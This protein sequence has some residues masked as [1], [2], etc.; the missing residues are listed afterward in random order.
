MNFNALYKEKIK[1]IDAYISDYLSNY[2]KASPNLID[3]MKYSVLNGGKRLRSVLCTEICAMLGGDVQKAM[4]FAC[5]IELIHAYSLVHDDLPA[6]DNADTR[7]GQPS[8]HKKYGESMGILCGD[9]LLNS[10]F[11]LMLS[12]CNDA[13]SVNASKILAET[14]GAEGMITGQV[15]DLTVGS[16]GNVTKDI[17]IDIIEQK[18]MA[19]IRGSVLAGA[20]IA[21]ADN[22]VIEQIENFDLEIGSG[23]FI[24]GFEDQ[25]IGK[26]SGEEF[27]VNVT[28]PEEYHAPELAGKE[29]LFKV[30]IHE[31]KAKELL[32]YHS[33]ICKQIISNY[34]NNKFLT[35]FLNY[36][37]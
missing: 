13:N 21:D 20:F 14:A 11:E 7:R 37:F 33:N 15:K 26:N 6:M 28:F 22:K 2:K 16:S 9:A 25:I 12:A 19:I 35:D 3:A 27:D 36:L 18:T 23:Q 31:I 1:L 8:C 34:N 29:A 4:P 32:E 30:K 5:A 24:P 17:L 10:A